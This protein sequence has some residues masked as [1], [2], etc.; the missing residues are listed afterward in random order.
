MLKSDLE[1]QA[2][3]ER[4]QIKGGLEKIRSDTKKLLDK[5]YGSATVFGSASIE[6]LL[7]YLIKYID[8]K[9]RKRLE[10]AKGGAG[11]VMELLPF[12]MAIDTE[13]QA[14]ITAKLTF[15]KVFSSRKENSKILK[16]ADAI[17]NSQGATVRVE[18]AGFNGRAP[19]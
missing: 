8:E 18:G 15:D 9:K 2:S 3:F 14:A 5:D 12:I 4:K 7:P 11:H 19:R 16:V 13:S 6:T 17:G 10:V 1:R